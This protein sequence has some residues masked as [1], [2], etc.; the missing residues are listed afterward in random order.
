MGF[1][2]SYCEAIAKFIL[3]VYLITVSEPKH[4]NN[5][6]SNVILQKM[7]CSLIVWPKIIMLRRKTRDK[8]QEDNQKCTTHT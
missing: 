4:I 2:D 5:Q 6:S 3:P 7:F 1:I 8:G